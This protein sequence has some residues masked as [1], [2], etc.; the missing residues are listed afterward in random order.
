MHEL[1]C[2]P[3]L[4]K[5]NES[6]NF[7]INKRA[8]IQEAIVGGATGLSVVAASIVLRSWSDAS[9]GELL[10]F[11]GAVI[12]AAATVAGSIFVLQWQRDTELREERALLLDLLGDVD[13]ACT[14]FQVANETALRERYGTTARQQVTEVRAAIGRVHEFRERIKPKTARMMRACGALSDLALM[15]LISISS[16]LR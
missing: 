5:Y 11:A 15:M 7:G 6:M 14:P 3:T 2:R 12:G 13:S 8:A 16:W 1:S 9:D 10:S 4:I